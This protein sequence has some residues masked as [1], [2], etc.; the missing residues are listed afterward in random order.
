MQDT[1]AKPASRSDLC[2]RVGA[3]LH[4]GA[5]ELYNVLRVWEDQKS[6]KCS[7]NST[8]GLLPFLV[9]VNHRARRHELHTGTVCVCVCVCVLRQGRSGSTGLEEY[10][11]TWMQTTIRDSLADNE[12]VRVSCLRRA[13]L[14]EH[15]VS[16]TRHKMYRIMK[17]VLKA[18]HGTARILIKDNFD[19][20]S[21][22]S[23]S[24]RAT[25]LRAYAQALRLQKAGKAVIVFYD[26][27]YINTGH[28]ATMTWYLDKSKRRL[29]GKGKRLIVLHALTKDGPVVCRDA[30]GNYIENADL[31]TRHCTAERIYEAKKAEGDY[32]DSMDSDTY[33][34]WLEFRLF[35]TLRALYPG[36]RIIAIKDNAMMM[37][38]GVV[39]RV[40]CRCR[41]LPARRSAAAGPVLGQSHLLASVENRQNLPIRAE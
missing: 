28:A 15:G 23:K 20:D 6:I 21:T 19:P 16:I 32:H 3:V 40:S 34:A 27:T 31:K 36:K 39:L 2:A 11:I 33:L 1:S 29:G 17:R 41:A 14:H 13:V 4:R 18:N 38:S 10:I 24:K 7:D 30:D 25:F 35:P 37:S 12:P 8:R 9:F 22:K 5:R 26:E